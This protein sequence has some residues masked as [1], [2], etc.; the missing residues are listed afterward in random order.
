[1]KIFFDHVLFQQTDYNFNY[2][3]VSAIFEKNEFDYALENGW[4]PDNFWLNDET[5]HSIRCKNIG[6]F[7]WSP[8]RS[9]RIKVAD[10][11]LDK[12]DRRLLKNNIDVEIKTAYNVDTEE[13]FFVYQKYIKAKK[14]DDFENCIDEFRKK[15]CRDDFY[16]LLY[17]QDSKLIGFCIVQ[18]LGKNLVSYQFCWDYENPKLSLGKFSQIQEVKF[19]ESLCADYVYIGCVAELEGVYKVQFPGFEYYTGREWKCRDELI[20]KWLSS[21]SKCLS[22]KDL[23]AL[24]DEYLQDYKP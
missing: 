9:S 13:I 20:E 21:D 14:F 7:V 3:L 2:T 8:I 10:F 18:P 22:I 12:K 24:T 4:F 1:M 17:K 15:F 23:V 16:Y 6:E 19:A 11:V 5:S